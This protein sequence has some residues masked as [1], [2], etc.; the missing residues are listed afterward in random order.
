[1]NHFEYQDGEP[2]LRRRFP[3]R[4]RLRKV[5]TPFHV[6]S[7]AT[8]QRHYNVFV[9]ALECAACVESPKGE[10]PFIAHAMKANQIECAGHLGVQGCGAP[11]RSAKAKLQALRAGIILASK[12]VLFWCRQ[13]GR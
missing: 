3:K 1:M 11:I 6:Y 13:T 5:G 9:D 7:S 8:L 4:T 10:S 12:I 2:N